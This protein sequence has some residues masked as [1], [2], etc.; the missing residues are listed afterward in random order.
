MK[1]E[2]LMAI[3]MILLNR[4]RVQAQELADKL[5]VSLRTIYRD[6]ESLS[7][8][9]IPLVSYTGT[10]GGYEIMEG[11][12]LDRQMLTFDELTALVTALRGLQSTQAL[13]ASNIDRL[14]EKVGTLVSQ[15]EQER[16]SGGHQ[17]QID[18]AP[19]KNSDSERK[20]YESL[21]QAV[22]G[23][24]RIRFHY[25]NAKGEDTER[26]IEPTGLALKG[27]VWYLHG[28]CLSRRA[29]RTFRLSRIRDL[30]VL[31]ETFIPRDL[32]EDQNPR[33]EWKRDANCPK[34][35][36]V[37]RISGD[38]KVHG[39]DR[40]EEHEIERQADGTILVRTSLPEGKWLTN[41]LLQFGTDLLVLEP[42]Y[43]A[44]KL[45]EAALKIAGLY[46]G[47]HTSVREVE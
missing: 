34:V 14:L 19:W 10:D 30:Q 33:W 7:M 13:E 3:T 9:G 11:Y 25:L 37:L 43:M 36:L 42:A 4:K 27:Y 45:Q 21:L 40:F 39:A 16:F 41:F 29:F 38:A 22:K 32:T 44:G 20:K 6:L 23:L 31:E 17:L 2:R 18:F 12:R 35:D 26:C 15:A 1:L 47:S 24:K 28:Y 5:E 8:A 46:G